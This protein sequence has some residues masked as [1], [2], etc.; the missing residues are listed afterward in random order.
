M[1][2]MRRFPE[3]AAARYTAAT[4]QGKTSPG[5]TTR[6]SERPLRVRNLPSSVDHANRNVVD[7]NRNAVGVLS[8]TL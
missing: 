1:W 6:S 5:Q 7:F 8:P 3:V 2:K 4:L